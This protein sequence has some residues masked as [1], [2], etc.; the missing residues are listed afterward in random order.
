MRALLIAVHGSRISAAND[1][2]RGFAT[3]LSTAYPEHWNQ[4]TTGFLEFGEP[5]LPEALDGLLAAGADRITVVPLFL[6]TGRHVSKDIPAAMAA[7]AQTH[8]DVQIQ[9]APHIGAWD[10]LGAAVA[11]LARDVEDGRQ[12]STV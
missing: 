5:S 2:L 11:T 4:V 6:S 3:Q 9:V 12:S 10:G 7:F 1:E 8:P